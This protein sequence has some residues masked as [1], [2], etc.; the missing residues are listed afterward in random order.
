[1]PLETERRYLDAH[2]D[3]LSQ[4]FGGKVLV[5]SGEEVTGA[6]DTIEEALHG[7]ISMHGLKN[8]LIRRASEAQ[9]EFAAP[10]LALG[11]INANTSQSNDRTGEN[12]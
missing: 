7:A 3:E 11:I 5:I 6:Y 9:I 12:S 8:V 4:R 2:K 10:A 1:M